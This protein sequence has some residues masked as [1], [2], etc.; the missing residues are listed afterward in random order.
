MNI[1]AK[2]EQICE[3]Q[4]VTIRRAIDRAKIGENVAEGSYWLMLG[5][6]AFLVK[7][8]T[9]V[10]SGQVSKAAKLAYNTDTALRDSIS[11]T[12]YKFLERYM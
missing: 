10:K 6:A 11:P 3:N 12:I 2:V 8:Y 5:D 7:L 9:L 4:I 1:P